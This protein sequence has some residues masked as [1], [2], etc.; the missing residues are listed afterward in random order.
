MI[1]IKFQLVL[2]NVIL[3]F[4]TSK[5]MVLVEKR[6]LKSPSHRFAYNPNAAFSNRIALCVFWKQNVINWVFCYYN[7]V[8]LGLGSGVGTWSSWS[9]KCPIIII[10]LIYQ[11]SLSNLN[12][13]ILHQIHKIYHLKRF[14]YQAFLKV[15]TF[16]AFFTRPFI[17]YW[18]HSIRK[19]EL[20][21]VSTAVVNTQLVHVELENL[22]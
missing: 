12:T 17:P 22:K 13:S 15:F 6:S 7:F 3:Q 16:G 9:I 5:K 1:Y 19:W 14:Y 2:R 8:I 11:V 21:Y 10:N 18:W 4:T 20:S